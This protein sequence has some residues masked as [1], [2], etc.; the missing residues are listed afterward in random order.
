MAATVF[1]RPSTHSSSCNGHTNGSATSSELSQ[2][3]VTTTANTYQL[4]KQCLRNEPPPQRGRSTNRRKVHELAHGIYRGATEWAVGYFERSQEGR[5]GA[6]ETRAGESRHLSILGCGH[7]PQ[8]AHSCEA[9]AS[10]LRSV[11]VHSSDTHT[12]GSIFNLMNTLLV[13][14]EQNVVGLYLCSLV[15][16]RPRNLAGVG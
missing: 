16:S 15:S 5:M 6:A 14:I 3:E 9:L 13:R 10:E 7:F 1:P 8:V 2:D 11:C 12:L 4:S